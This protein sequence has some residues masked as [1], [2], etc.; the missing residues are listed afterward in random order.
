MNPNKKFKMNTGPT[1]PF[2]TL[3]E[4]INLL[5]DRGLIIHDRESALHILNNTNYYRLSAYSLTLRQNDCFSEGTT[6]DDICMLYNFD[7]AFRKIIL[8]YTLYIEVSMRAF[9]SYEFSKKYGPLGYMDQSNFVSSSYHAEFMTHLT[10]SIRKSDDLFVHYHKSHCNSVFPF[11]VAVECCMFGDLSKFYKNMQPADRTY[12]AKKYFGVDRRYIE[13]W[14]QATVYA[15]NI[16]AH[17][18]RFY[19][20][21]FRSIR[22]RLDSKR[23]TIINSDSVFAYVYVIHKLQ[24]SPERSK[25]MCDSIS[26]LFDEYPSAQLDMMGFPADWEQILSASK[27]P[28]T[29]VFK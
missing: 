10:E 11:W 4:Q 14:L 17:G 26:S 5:A 7:D 3:E 15:R 13:N 24:T 28:D 12:I 16:A 2:K 19:N 27:K 1:K 18:G 8:Q 20:R 22:V 25:S 23:K 29:F 6:F 21:V 9:I